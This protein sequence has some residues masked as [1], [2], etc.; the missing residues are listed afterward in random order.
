MW[1]YI[2]TKIQKRETNDFFGAVR[3][4]V[5][6]CT[7]L[8]TVKRRRKVHTCIYSLAH[9]LINIKFTFSTIFTNI[10][11]PLHYCPVVL[12]SHVV[13]RFFTHR[14]PLPSYFE[15]CTL[16]YRNSVTLFGKL[17]FDVSSSKSTA[18]IRWKKKRWKKHT[19]KREKSTVASSIIFVN[20][21]L[22]Y[23]IYIYVGLREKKTLILCTF[24]SPL[25]PP[26]SCM[27]VWF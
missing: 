25:P 27:W 17:L 12:F 7:I 26:N 19:P 9:F 8:P 4:G 2:G 22:V 1:S 18:Y 5:S 24:F 20:I 6:V 3:R 16:S 23:R 10:H 11:T 14:S 13:S 21:E 15:G